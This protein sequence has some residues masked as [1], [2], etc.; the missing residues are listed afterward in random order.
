M[1][2]RVS[3]TLISNVYGA[4]VETTLSPKEIEQAAAYGEPTVDVGGE[5]TYQTGSPATDHTFTVTGQQRGI[6]T[7]FPVSQSFPGG[8]SDAALKRDAWADEIVA[9]LTAAKVALMARPS[10]V[11]P[12][13]STVTV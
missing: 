9:R 2:I 5:F 7:G 8:D 10:V 11:T 1:D 4:T 12:D 13:V 3:K 6:R